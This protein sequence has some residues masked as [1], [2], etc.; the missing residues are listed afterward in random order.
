[1]SQQW[2]AEQ[3]P[4]QNGALAIVTGANSGLG[5]ITANELAR[6]GAEENSP[7]RATRCPTRHNPDHLL[8]ASTIGCSSPYFSH[9]PGRV[10]GFDSSP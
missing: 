9:R 6:H 1:M 7:A 5:L 4:D 10:S 8:T 3:I 2:T